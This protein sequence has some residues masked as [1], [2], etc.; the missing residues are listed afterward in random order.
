MASLFTVPPESIGALGPCDAAVLVAALVRADAAVSGM[1]C[2]EIDIPVSVAAVDGG[3]VD[4]IAR[5]APRQSRRGLVKKGTTAYH[6]RS[7][8]LAPGGG[9]GDMLFTRTG[10]IRERIRSCIEEDGALT[11]FLTGWDDADSTDV[12]MSGRL[13]QALASRSESCAH[14]RIDVWGRSRI[15]SA[16]E[17]FPGLAL[18]MGDRASAWISNHAEWS[19]LADMSHTF[20]SGS[21][22]NKFI[23]DMRERLR[24]GD[25]SGP[26]HVHVSGEPGSGKT[27]LVLEATRAAD[28]APRIVYAGNSP[29]GEA[30]L[31]EILRGARGGRRAAAEAPI[32]VVDECDPSAR[33]S[34]LNVL[35]NNEN[36]VH[37][38]TIDGGPDEFA[39]GDD[40]LPV[41]DMADEEIKRI[42]QYYAGGGGDAK[43]DRWVDHA[44]PSP[45]AAH[46]LGANL[47]SNPLNIFAPPCNVSAWERW[48][49]GGGGRY[50][51]REYDD[52]YTVLL[53]LSLFTRFG[54]DAP[55][56]ADAAAIAEMISM[57][58]PDMQ[59]WR[60][61]EVVMSL[62]NSRVLR[63]SSV[64][65]ITPRLLHDYLWLKWWERYGDECAPSAADLAMEG[66]GDG[67]A[68]R[69]KRYCDMFMR[70]RD[71]PEARAIAERL[72]GPGGLFGRREDLRRSLN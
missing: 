3:G 6:I 42:L 46:I 48:I 13:Q 33:A 21:A 12:E 67:I 55:H 20:M 61:R 51:G 50:S 45:R 53:W 36:G 29:D 47:S 71:R 64:L 35:M 25:A 39:G 69:S 8:S 15:A 56:E 16:M 63:G 1:S 40:L 10:A 68:S 19:S 14:A 24:S 28:I 70:M 7:G 27:R 34:L 62:R 22:E 2:T 17:K 38:V 44:S 23:L 49:A 65:C 60:F 31:L 59:K 43:I 32:F 57:H 54:F 26:V 41:G 30:V 4:G 58:H 5:G 37:L 18:G 66:G 52:R 9:I 11:V 72:L